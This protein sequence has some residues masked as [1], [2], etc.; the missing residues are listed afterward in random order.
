MKRLL[1]IDGHSL[2]Y[3]AF[4][5]LPPL[6]TR[7]GFPSNAVY[8]FLRM[9]IKL[10]KEYKPNYGAVAFDTPK[11][12]FRHREFKEYKIK[13]PEMPDKL[14][15]Q[16]EVAKEIIRAMGIKTIEMEGF[17]ADDIIGTIS[18]KAEGEGLEVFIVSGDRD[19]LQLASD[20]TKIIR[21]IKGISDIEIY[22]RNRVIQ[23]YGV[24]PSKIPH[25]IALKGDQSD[26]IPGIP[27]IGMKR[28]QSLLNRYGDIDG[29]ISRSDLKIIKENEE[30]LRLYLSIATIKRDAPIDIKIE[31]LKILPPRKEILFGLL[32]RLEFHSFLKELGL[33]KE[34]I[35]IEERFPH[36]IIESEREIREAL[37]K[38]S[39]AREIY[40]NV[41]ST[42]HPPM[43]ASIRGFCLAS[44]ERAFIFLTHRFSTFEILNNIHYILTSHIPKIGHDL[45][46]NLVLIKREGFNIKNIDFDVSLASYLL[47]S[48]KSSHTIE[49]LALSHLE[50]YL[51]EGNEIVRAAEEAGTCL[52]IRKELQEELEKEGL[53]T[54]FKEVELPLTNVL[55]E[56]EVEGIRLDERELSALEIEIEREIERIENEIFLTVGKRFNINSPKQLSEVLYDHLG[57]SPPGKRKKRS[58]D[59]Q[60]LTELIRAGGPYKEV[61]EKIL[62]YR[63][64]MKLKSSYISNLPKLIHPKTRCI[65]TVFNQTITATGRLS[66]SDPNLQNIPIRSPIGKAIRKAFTVKKEENILISADYSQIELRILAHFSGEP[67][68][69]EAFER[70]ID[71]HARTAAEIFGVDEKNVT[72]EQRRIA[73]VINFGIIYGMS[74]HGLAQELGI[75]RS[76]AESYIKRYFSRYPRVKEYIESLISE[77]REK[78]YVKTILGRKRK[79]EGLNSRYKKL[80]EQA[81][82]YAIN[83]PMQGSAADIIKLAMVKLHSELKSFKMLL[84]IHDE[85]LFEGPEDKLSDEVEKIKSIMTNAVRLS[86]PLKVSIKIGKNWGNMVN[87]P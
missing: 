82:R 2:L 38:L 84:Q 54:L 52:S 65:H 21:T 20:R 79:I 24:D 14:R 7:D 56:M 77:T 55:A 74:P 3:R 16:I 29:I 63:G 47:D 69:L 75:S 66:S 50:K 67:R 85:L 76:E 71:I 81:E 18:L 15:P 60:T 86:V 30:K 31:N 32:K 44:E 45:K 4:Y 36:T 37:T 33:T 68:L 48:T 87:Y 34:E 6:G 73:K 26:D 8:G 5:A 41:M 72:P 83:T 22:D 19:A 58:T 11:P 28:A 12:T 78:G 10:L 35:K 62:L 61:I 9:L 40:I 23:E 64:L 59:A 70:D 27:S 46:R 42:D 1:L 25:L 17:E 39:K 13:R 43:W 49:A 80:R 51:P 53:W 57:L